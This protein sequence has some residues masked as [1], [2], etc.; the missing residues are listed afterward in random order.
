[1]T[2]SL[3]ATTVVIECPC[4]TTSFTLFFAFIKVDFYIMGL[5]VQVLKLSKVRAM[6]EVEISCLKLSRQI[7]A[8]SCCVNFLGHMKM[9]PLH[10]AI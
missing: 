10:L 3:G 2:L 4:P 6:S 9:S 1:M 5:G 7:Q 8:N